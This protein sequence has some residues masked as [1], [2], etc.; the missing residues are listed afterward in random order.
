MYQ[1][2][3][4]KDAQKN[5]TFAKARAEGKLVFTM[6][7]RNRKSDKKATRLIINHYP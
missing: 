6:P 2:V 4:S 3:K 1:E 7:S 5:Q